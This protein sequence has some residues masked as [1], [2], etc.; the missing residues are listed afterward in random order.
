MTN[1]EEYFVAHLKVEKISKPERI[2]SGERRKKG[3]VTSLVI[4]AKDIET[5]RSKVRGHLELI[6]DEAIGYDDEKAMR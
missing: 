2:P 5:L 4:R 3:E 6:D 1:S